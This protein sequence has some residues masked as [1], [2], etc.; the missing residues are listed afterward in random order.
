MFHMKTI[1]HE[2]NASRRNK[3]FLRGTKWRTGA[4]SGGKPTEYVGIGLLFDPELAG[5]SERC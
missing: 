5:E 2:E 1:N 3:P 4:A